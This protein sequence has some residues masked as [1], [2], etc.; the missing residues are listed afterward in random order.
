[1]E[2]RKDTSIT[3]KKGTYSVLEKHNQLT[4]LNGVNM[5]LVNLKPTMVHQNLHMVTLVVL[6]EEDTMQGD[7]DRDQRQD[8]HQDLLEEAS[9]HLDW[10]E[11]NKDFPNSNRLPAKR[12][13]TAS[14]LLRSRVPLQPQDGMVAIHHFHPI[15]FRD[16]LVKRLMVLP[17]LG[18]VMD[19]LV[20]LVH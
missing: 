5:P 9:L 14:N 1:M 16:L 19:N 13:I 6:L 18:Q 12:L 8:K 17:L 2:K 3:K 10:L 4:L 11:N 7:Q 20:V 15:H